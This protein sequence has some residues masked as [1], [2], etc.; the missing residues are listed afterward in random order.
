MV[1]ANS[2]ADRAGALPRLGSRVRIPSPAPKSPY[3]IAVTGLSCRRCLRTSGEASGRGSLALTEQSRRFRSGPGARPSPCL[4]TFVSRACDF[5]ASNCRL[6]F[7]QSYDTYRAGL[8]D[9]GERP[10][11]KVV[12]RFVLEVLPYALSALIVAII[13][14]GFLSAHF[15]ATQPVRAVDGGVGS[16]V[17]ALE[18][19]RGDHAAFAEPAI[20]GLSSSA[21]QRQVLAKQLIAK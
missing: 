8:T 6:N 9:S 1:V 14:P 16:N 17:G 10:V 12:S 4:C 13:V 18:L 3:R 11:L 7:K 20:S 2:L 21:V 15:H 19:V 5:S